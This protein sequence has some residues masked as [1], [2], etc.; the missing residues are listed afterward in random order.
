MSVY[1]NSDLSFGYVDGLGALVKTG[2]SGAGSEPGTGTT[3][4]L[5]KNTGGS[6]QVSYWGSDNLFPQQVVADV[7][8]NTSLPT[9]LS[10]KAKAWYGGGVVYGLVDLDDQGNETF[11]RIRIP[12]VEQFLRDNDL[13]RYAFE[14]YQNLSYFA[15][16]WVELI[17]SRNRQKIVHI[18]ALD[19]CYCRYSKGTSAKDVMRYIYHNANW[20]NGGR[21][22]DEYCTKIPVLEVYYRKVD[23][24]RERTDGFKYAYPLNIPS[25]DKSEYQLADWNSFRS[26]GWAEVAKAVVEFKKMLLKQILSVEFIIE[27][28]PAYW[29]WKY[30]DWEEKSDE[31]RRALIGTE[32]KN[33]GEVMSG[34]NGAGKSLMTT[35]VKDSQGNDVAAF[36]VTVLDKK[37][38]EGLFNEDS[39]EAASHV[40]TAAGVAPTL[41]GISPGKSQG[42]AGSGSDARVAFNN[43]IST[44]TFE[45]DQVTSVLHFIRDY[46]N[47]PEN[48]EFRF[49]QPLIMTLDKGK[50]T[51]QETA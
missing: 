6:S 9:T 24:L 26:S 32:L 36:K 20:G 18:A 39:Q 33:F 5:L 21:Y 15:N 10:W 4:S 34:S 48:L 3:V 25:P 11:R 44:S 28:N 2:L 50:Q 37:M 8:V 45:Q 49:K 38:K 29:S 19:S 12:E 40:Y 31:E 23:A 17:L 43:F 7:Q 13:A 1:V 14:T 22:D 51:Q 30:K 47:W 41:M 42:S 16:A 35:T 46:N 27:V